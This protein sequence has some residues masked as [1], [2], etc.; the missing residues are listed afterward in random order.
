[1]KTVLIALNSKYIHTALGIRSISVYC[2]EKGFEVD[3]AEKT[4]QTP[5]L[6]VL[7]DVME[8]EPDVVGI[9]VHIWNKDYAF[10]LA[11]LIRKV[12]PQTIVVLGG[13]EVSFSANEAFCE[14]GAADYIVEG[15]GEEAFASFLAGFTITED[16]CVKHVAR[17]SKQASEGRNLKPAI[18]NDISCLPFPYPDL[19]RVKEEQKIVYYECTR[20]CPFSCSYCLSGIGHIV[21]KKPLAKV[22]A[23]LSLLIEAGIP[24]VKFVDRTYNLDEAY[25]LPIME[26][27]AERGKN[28]VFHFEIKAD[29]LSP[30][31]L[32]FL[33][34]VPK[35]RFQFE[36]GVQTTNQATC[37]AIGRH[38][39]WRLLEKNVHALL[40]FGNINLHLDLI[41]GLPYEGL[42]SFKK[43]F[44]DVYSLNPH[45]LQL[46]F[47]KVLNGSRI[48]GQRD[49]YGIVHMDE[50]PYEVLYTKNMSYKEIFFLKKLEDLFDHTYNSGK[51]KHAL[52]CLVRLVGRGS[53]FLFYEHLTCWWHSRGL[54]A[55]DHNQRNIYLY[56]KEYAAENLSAEF[57][58]VVEALRF[59]IFLYNPGWRPESFEWHADAFKALL[60]DFWRN[61]ELVR[62]YVPEYN[63]ATWRKIRKYYS[64]ER[65]SRHPV[66]GVAYEFLALT[67]YAEDEPSYIELEKEDFYANKV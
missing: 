61:D 50:A 51:F 16:E 33:K 31:V 2:R 14:C 41:A 22:F 42:D 56:L 10:S 24:L 57:E 5:I 21:R 1:M 65:F 66:T 59:D 46:G 13:P 17:R 58:E 63:F 12:R 54:F 67:N 19:D 49:D 37:E 43:S 26:F 52:A 25:F 3:F 32:E 44:N 36:I 11:N 27:L 15:E 4:I 48:Y 18:V 39:D 45:M 29:L 55:R 23:E 38:D 9:D 62:K 20:G 34:T 28:S 47:L 35:G 64:I 7:S 8:E 6:K 60:L 53:A 40:S 30:A